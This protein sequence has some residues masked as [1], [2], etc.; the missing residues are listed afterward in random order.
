MKTKREIITFKADDALLEA[1]KGVRN[2]SEFIRT[3]ISNALE[4]T[5]PL[6]MGAG[7]LSPNQRMHWDRFCTDHSI[8]ECDRCHETLIVCEGRH[9]RKLDRQETC[10]A[11]GPGS[12]N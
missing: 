6:C 4:N 9:R 12:R 7:V 2:R 1:L 3:A 10:K 5:C 11:H 8:E